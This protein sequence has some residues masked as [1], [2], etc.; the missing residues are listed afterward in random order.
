MN[1]ERGAVE[2][3]AVEMG[4]FFFEKS[5]VFGRKKDTQKLSLIFSN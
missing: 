1:F 2:R 3:G 4:D 5:G